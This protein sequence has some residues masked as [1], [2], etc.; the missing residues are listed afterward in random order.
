MKAEVWAL[1][2]TK[3]LWSSDRALERK[4]YGYEDNFL[5]YEEFSFV[6]KQ[7]IFNIWI[8]PRDTS[9]FR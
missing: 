4:N 3:K 8:S 5:G 7:R 1:F 9:S 6:A 2:R